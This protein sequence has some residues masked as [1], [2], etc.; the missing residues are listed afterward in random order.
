MKAVNLPPLRSDSHWGLWAKRHKTRAQGVSLRVP[1]VTAHT[2]K[3]WLAL[4]ASPGCG[5]EHEDAGGAGDGAPGLLGDVDTIRE[6]R[7]ER[8]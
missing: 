3:V 4:P 5:V 2:A 1:S 7:E 6:L 8:R